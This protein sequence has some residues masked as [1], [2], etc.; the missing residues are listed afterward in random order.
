MCVDAWKAA[1][2][3][4]GTAVG[5]VGPE[6]GMNYSAT[7]QTCHQIIQQLP[8][9]MC[10]CMHLAVCLALVVSHALVVSRCLDNG[11]ELVPLD[12]LCNQ[13]CMHKG[14]L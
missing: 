4:A 11:A 7:L 6:M 5:A 1:T 14:L 10:T 13:A 12:V 2:N 8:A 3:A 9:L